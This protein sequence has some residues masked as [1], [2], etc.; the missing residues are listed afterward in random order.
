MN[1]N[2]YEQ[3]IATAQIDLW[4]NHRPSPELL[5]HARSC[6]SC[7]QRI[8]RELQLRLVLTELADSSRHSEPSPLVKH[9]LLAAFQATYPAGSKRNSFGLRFRLRFGLAAA[10]MVCLAIGIGLFFRSNSNSDPHTRPNDAAITTQAPQTLPK[11]ALPNFSAATVA[12][13]SAE[14]PTR[15]SQKRAQ[16]Q[17]DSTNDFY[18][19]VMCDSITCAGPTVAVRV[20]L[21]ASPLAG[22]EGQSRNVMADLLVG[23]DGLV[24]GVRVLQ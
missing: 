16:Q 14:K 5:E 11:T 18:P 7:G 17:A 1:C 15:P 23:E 21:Q 2:W 10:A 6:D 9:N 3:Q 22:R 19:L 24:R 20:E 4:P 8:D 13:A 12:S